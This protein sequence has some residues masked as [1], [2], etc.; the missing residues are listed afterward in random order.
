METSLPPIPTP[1]AQR[2]REFRIQIL[3]LIIFAGVLVAVAL[4][5]KNFV[6]PSGIVGEVEAVK[7][8]VISLK[9]GTLVELTVDRFAVVTKDQPIGLILGTD[10]ALLEASLTAISAELKLMQARMELDKTRNL[11]AYTQLRIS[12]LT[13]K[14]ALSLAQVRVKQADSEFQRMSKLY[15]LKIVGSGPSIG[16]NDF[17]YEVAERDRDALQIEIADRT[18]L[19]EQLGKD[20]QNLEDLGV[21]QLV[22]RDPV[23]E[24][25]I[26]AQQEKLRLEEKP[27]I[28]KAPVDGVVSFIFKRA[29]EKVVRGEPLVTISV[30]T[31]DRIIGYLRQPLGALPTTNDTVTVRTRTVKRQIGSAQVLRVGAQLEPINPA[32]TT[33]PARI[34]LGL[35]FL[36]TLPP[37]FNLVPGEFVDLSIQY[38]RH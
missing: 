14:V 10:P 5:W 35:P 19:V 18:K 2:W 34:E 29:G 8:N 12:L 3:P 26:R 11:D 7:A 16:G 28:L 20:I 38:A 15:E 9:D 36:I 24:E 23:I 13:E 33:D 27:V 1:S 30:P 37:G 6:Q 31:S 17:G 22:P 4:M 32:L 21:A 25:N